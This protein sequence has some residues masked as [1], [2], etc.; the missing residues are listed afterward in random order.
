MSEDPNAYYKKYDNSYSQGKIGGGATGVGLT[1]I[2]K[3]Q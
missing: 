3:K 1:Q 2:L